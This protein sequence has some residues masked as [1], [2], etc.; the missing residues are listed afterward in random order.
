LTGNGGMIGLPVTKC[1]LVMGIAVSLPGNASA[2]LGKMSF[3]DDKII[4]Y[5]ILEQLFKT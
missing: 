4:V 5:G 1:L 3:F 2:G